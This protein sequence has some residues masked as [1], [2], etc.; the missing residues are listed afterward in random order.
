[1]DLAAAVCNLSEK[2]T[3]F[4]FSDSKT[5]LGQR[6]QHGWANVGK[7]TLAHSNFAR[8]PNMLAY[9]WANVGMVVCQLLANIN[10]TLTNG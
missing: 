8:W 9:C 3:C 5:E 2:I 6:L 4:A 10:T 7:C 1:M